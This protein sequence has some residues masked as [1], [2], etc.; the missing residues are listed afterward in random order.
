VVMIDNAEN[1]LILLSAGTAE[2]RLAGRERAR[3]L[4][5]VCSWPEL[6]AALRV[7]KL[8]PVLGP[9]ILELSQGSVC[10]DFGMEVDQAIEQGRRHGAFVQLVGLR[11]MTLLANEGIR[12]APLKGPFLGE[13]I[14]VDIGRRLSSDIDI[15]VAAEQLPAAVEVV[16]SLGYEAPK[17]HV[18]RDGLP[19]LHFAMAHARAQLPPIELHWRIHWYERSFA[20]ECLLPP[21]MATPG[22]WRPR[23]T[24]ELAALLLFYARDGFIDLRAAADLGAWWDAFGPTVPRDSFGKLLLAHPALSRVLLAAL[25]AA[26]SLIGLPYEQILGYV[27]GLDRRGRL[28]VRLANP[29]PS[30]S[31]SQLYADSGLIDGLL[32]PPRGLGAFVRRQVLPPRGVLEEQARHA[33]RRRVR[34]RLGRCLGVLTRY[35]LTMARSVRA[36]ERL[37]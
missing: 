12:S 32:A 36:R 13:A 17:D 29:H 28:A 27:P 35:S 16:R 33:A 20:R 34:S 23:P 4:A 7:R 1:R 24:N 30:A 10:E 5:A 22:E 8:L 25:V 37:V 26:G 6:T 31:Q 3:E 2:R 15:L 19:L 11:V 14:H 21:G 9:R 18:G